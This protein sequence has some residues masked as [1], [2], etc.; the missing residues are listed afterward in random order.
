M[1]I[2]NNTQNI[3]VAS[4]NGYTLEKVQKGQEFLLHY[5]KDRKNVTLDE[6]VDMY[7]YLRN[8]NEKP[9]SCKP[10]AL[11]KYLLGIEN[12]VKYGKL[13]LINTNKAS[14]SDFNAPQETKTVEVIENITERIKDDTEQIKEVVEAFQEVEKKKKGR[15]KKV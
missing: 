13:T 5:G 7:N 11:Q 15:P 2:R 14:E 10:C 9:R 12:Y 6:I 4:S 8:T 1:L 3:S